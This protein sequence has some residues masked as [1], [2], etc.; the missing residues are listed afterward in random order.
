MKSHE[1]DIIDA[2]REPFVL[3]DMHQLTERAHMQMRTN[4]VLIEQLVTRALGDPHGVYASFGIGVQEVLS[5]F[6]PP[7]T[8]QPYVVERHS[9]AGLLIDSTIDT[10]DI[11]LDTLNG[12]RTTEPGM[13]DA[14]QTIVEA[15]VTTPSTR[16]MALFGAALSH[17]MQLG[18]MLDE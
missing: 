11:L 5:D 9:A 8:P 4:H 16:D 6:I 7:E 15:H 18:Q 12:F 10:R 13:Y 17:S 3:S 1:S 2:L 14:V